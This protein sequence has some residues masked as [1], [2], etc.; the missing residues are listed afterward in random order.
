MRPVAQPTSAIDVGEW[1]MGKLNSIPP[2]M[3]AQMGR[4]R[5]DFTTGLEKTTSRPMRRSKSR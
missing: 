3:N 5:T 2:E 1:A 4:I